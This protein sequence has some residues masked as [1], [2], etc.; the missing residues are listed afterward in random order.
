MNLKSRFKKLLYSST[1]REE[2]FPLYWNELE[3]AYQN[4]SRAYHNLSHLENMFDEWEQCQ[5]IHQNQQGLEWAIFYH[6][7]I[8]KATKKNNELKSAQLCEERLKELDIPTDVRSLC[9]EMIIATQKHQKSDNE[10]IN[11]MLD[12]DMSILGQSW[13]AYQTYYEGVRKEYAIYP[14]FLYHPGRVKVLQTF[15]QQPIF[16]TSFFKDKYEAKAIENI[17]TEIAFLEKLRKLIVL[18]K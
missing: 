12:L 18:E 4:N 3:K 13:E 14:D 10:T 2:L 8:Y 9:F 7:I 17:K 6:D 11:L 5:I 15:L 1:T 16:H